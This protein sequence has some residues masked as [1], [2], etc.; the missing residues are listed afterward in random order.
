M[1]ESSADLPGGYQPAPQC[2]LDPAIIPLAQPD[3]I[4]EAPTVISRNLP[5]TAGGEDS[6]ND[7]RGR[8]LAHFELLD[9]IGVGGMAAVLR[10]RDTQL[11][12]V[13][14]LKILPPDL[15]K[16][17]ENVRRFHQEARSAAKLD[18]EN[19]ARVFFCGEDQQLHFIAFEFVEGENLRTILENRGRLPVGEALHYMVQVAAGLAH[20][21]QRG[22]VHRDIKPSNIIITPTGRAKLVDMGLA[23]SLE[24][25]LDGGLTQSGVT[26]GTFDY[27]SPEQALEP[28]DADVRSD[29]Y[30]L[31]CTFYHMITGTPPVP[32]GTAARKLHH[33]QHVKPRDPRDLV[34]GLP[35][36]VAVILDHMLAKQPRDRY[37][38]PPQLVHHLLQAAR[39]VGAAAEVPEGVLAMEAVVPSARR[40]RP[41]LL[42][43]LTAIA[44]ILVIVLLG[45]G[46]PSVHDVVSQTPVAART[47]KDREVSLPGEK[48][49]PVAP[50]PVRTAVNPSDD[51]NAVYDADDPTA[52]D[53][54]KWLKDHARAEVLDIRLAHDIDLTT[55]SHNATT[56]PYLVFKAPRVI[57]GPRDKT[58]PVTVRLAYETNNNGRR[59]GIFIDSKE[60]AVDDLCFLVDATG[61]DADLIGLQLAPTGSYRINRCQ[62]VQVNVSSQEPKKDRGPVSVL[63]E[64]LSARHTKLQMSECCFL[65]FGDV[66][67][68]P[69]ESGQLDI[70]QPTDAKRG[71][72]EAVIRHGPVQIEA[73]DCAFGPHAAVFYL[74]GKAGPAEEVLVQHCSVLQ[75]RQ[76]AAFAL[77]DDASAV[78][79]VKYSLFARAG[80]TKGERD[81][82]VLVRQSTSPGEFTYDGHEN[83][84]HLDS[85]WI[86]SPPK[87]AQESSRELDKNPWKEDQPLKQLEALRFADPAAKNADVA[88]GSQ[89]W[90]QIRTA[91]QVNTDRGADVL[92]S[93]LPHSLI[94]VE[95]LGSVSFLANLREKEPALGAT[96]LV[97]DP[98]AENTGNGVYRSL[99]SA[100]P[101]AKPGDTILIKANGDVAIKPVRLE[102]ATA[103]L[104]I[105]PYRDYHP[106]LVLGKVAEDDTAL[107]RVFD[108]KL[109]LEDLEFRLE[110]RDRNFKAQAV[111]TVNGTGQCGFKNCVVTLDAGGLSASLAVASIADSSHIMKS[112]STSIPAQPHLEF[113]NCVVRG[114][115][116][117]VWSRTGRTLDLDV[118]NSLVVLGGN[119]LNIDLAME[120]AATAVNASLTNV[121]AYQTGN[122][123]RVSGG[124]D[125]KSLPLLA[126]KTTN[127]LFVSV[128]GHTLIHLEGPELTTDQLKDKVQWTAGENGNVYAGF[129]DMLDQRPHGEEMPQPA[130]VSDKWKAF[131]GEMTIK[132][133]RSV[134]FASAPAP[135]GSF[136]RITPANFKAADLVGFGADTTNLPRPAISADS[137]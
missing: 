41:V 64:G 35:D 14:A 93:D 104:T 92:P 127:C 96:E 90:D 9:R 59:A 55:T 118:R 36:D 137:Q 102:E 132:L 94:G 101:E 123:L 97:V 86:G 121:T 24:P 52:A 74:D 1:S 60:G 44:V 12:R 78:L 117:L 22:V 6:K 100:I 29:I 27:I 8:K 85:F 53:L 77:G 106:V 49:K 2:N 71:G 73:V 89:R 5:R 21:A 17:E 91:F 7:I 13:V 54:A 124:K 116:D 23:R 18:H 47:T 38:S 114:E 103:N 75:G 70:L 46:A 56:E 28:R 43:V 66:N 68:V 82:A 25:Q 136:T 33:H 58:K 112:G 57:I 20:A 119:F 62:F 108:G 50:N 30:S 51:K 125:V 39:K 11:D 131:T 67:R 19:V 99:S 76:S 113:E 84:Y 48:D 34:P 120:P 37:Q 31:G 15:A 133:L 122:F 32:D 16:D 110:P 81:G 126:C 3:A 95:H 134:K 130:I 45:Q 63:I 72:F 61:W 88:L 65:G 40:Y 69:N 129:N 87:L 135:E 83:R 4:D 79:K 115:G 26:L 98:K 111:A 128:A 109:Q 105:R 10:A 107:F 42:A 80:E